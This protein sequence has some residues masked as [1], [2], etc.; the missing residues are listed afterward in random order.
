[1][2]PRATLPTAK[3]EH[4]EILFMQGKQRRAAAGN[5]DYC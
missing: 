1:M 2:L 4:R 3:V 5:Q